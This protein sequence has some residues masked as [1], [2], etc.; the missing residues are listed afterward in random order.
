M[1]QSD[2]DLLRTKID[3]S[4][5]L[6]CKDGEVIVGKVH[7]V[8]ED[9]RDVIYDL[10]SSNRPTQYQSFGSCAFRLA[11]DEIEFVSLPES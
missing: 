11:F 9:E 5:Q 3:Q 1:N 2:I 6:H 8:S 4:I 10:I 7:F